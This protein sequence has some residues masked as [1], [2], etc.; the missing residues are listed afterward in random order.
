MCPPSLERDKD[1]SEY[2]VRGKMSA[3]MH[4]WILH[5]VPTKSRKGQ[6]PIEKRLAP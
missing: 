5:I 3:G 2:D 4:K 1:H 6:R